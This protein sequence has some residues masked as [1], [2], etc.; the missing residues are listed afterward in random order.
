MAEKNRQTGIRAGKINDGWILA[1]YLLLFFSVAAALAI[2]QPHLCN[3]PVASHPPDEPHRYFVSRFICRY[4]RLPN[5]FDPEIRIPGWGIS[6]G[7]YTMLPYMVQGYV[8]RF[9]NLFTD[10]ELILLYTA[11]FV[12]VCTGTAMAAVVYGIGGR[13][14]SDRRFK[15]LFCFLV[16][17]LPQSLFIHSYVNTDS[18]ALFSTSVIVY[19]WIRAYRE[20][21]GVKIDLIL[22]AGIILCALS[23]YN[24]YGF[25]LSS[26]LLFLA[27]FFRKEDGKRRYDWKSMLRNGLLISAV[28]LLGTGWYF[29]RNAVLYDGDILGLDS[30][31]RCGE[32]YGDPQLLPYGRSYA[33]RGVPFLD[34]LKEYYFKGLIE[35]FIAVYGSMTIFATHK[36]YVLYILL[37]SAGLAAFI[38]VPGKGGLTELPGGV[39]RVFL[40]LN[41][42]FCV[43][44]PL[45]LCLYYAYA[46]DYQYQGRYIMPGLI[47]LMYFV[48]AG[49]KKLA[50]LKWL[51][52]KWVKIKKVMRLLASAAVYAAMAMVVIILLKMVFVYAMP[53]YLQAGSII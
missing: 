28:V 50:D 10:S 12:N 53:V 19:A 14:F 7:F 45:A 20:G 27:A 31:R 16:M 30:L 2:A 22:A 13:L 37:L 42:A 18:M 49:L 51:P 39:E 3:V 17:F 9:V 52:Q 33:A 11:R 25:I 47:P 34:M 4:G 44:M 46:M 23:Y 32:L 43:L 1:F 36:M 8:M 21:F 48:T 26:I 15:W 41:M 5:G 24:A 29:I 35:S 38:V 40:H 6:Y